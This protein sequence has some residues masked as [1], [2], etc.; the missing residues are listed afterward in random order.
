MAV[1]YGDQEKY[2]KSAKTDF[3][4]YEKYEPE[5]IDDVLGYPIVAIPERGLSKVTCSHFE[6]R[7]KL[8]EL[9]E[10]EAIYFPC[11]KEEGE[12]GSGQFYISG[13]KKKD[14]TKPKKVPKG[15]R[16]YHFTTVG[17]VDYDCL[18]FGIAQAK[19]FGFNRLVISEGEL[20]AGAYWESCAKF[21]KSRGDTH[22]IADLIILSIGFGT[23]TALKHI[24][25]DRNQY[26]LSKVEHKMLAFDN[27]ETTIEEYKKGQRKGKEATKAVITAY[28]GYKVSNTRYELNDPNDMHL[29]GRHD[30]LFWAMMKPDDY[31][32]DSFVDVE[33]FQDQLIILPKLGRLWPWESMNRITYGKNEG[34]GY[35]FGS[36]IGQG[37]SLIVDMI[38]DFQRENE[39]E[40]PPT[41]FKFEEQPEITIRKL[42]GIENNI[43]FHDPTKVIY[44]GNVDVWGDAI[45][46][47]ARGFF[48]EEDLFNAR[49]E[50][51]DESVIIYNTE[52]FPDWEKIK[53]DIRYAT[54]IRGSK[55][56]IIDPLTA[57][58]EG[59]EPSA[60]NTLLAQIARDLYLMSNE[61]GFNFYVFCH[62]NA[63][64][65][66]PPHEEGGKVHGYQFTGSK[67]MMRAA[68]GQ[69]GLE[70]D[71]REE[72]PSIIRNMSSL[73]LLKDR[74]YG[75][76]GR[77]FLHYDPDT[78]SYEEPSK[79]LLQDYQEALEELKGNSKGNPKGREKGPTGFVNED[80]V[81]DM[82]E[83]TE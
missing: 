6:I 83:A 38:V 2:E 8:N 36:G 27:D 75:N 40:A 70:R 35:Y 17:E 56:I 67:A 33:K 81:G 79:D 31:S 58:F 39:P 74:V 9:D 69:W 30:E 12:V 1:G 49:C 10:V 4:S 37:K 73:N 52:G 46:S 22:K 3:K 65:F 25:T 14:L 48:N 18:L 26:Y 51:D 72:L 55:D 11:H 77:F 23:A 32:S 5:S 78:G 59:L 41:I 63:P 80:W 28:P 62:L 76:T 82:K 47:G 61:I 43:R 24:S 19:S 50:F 20:D 13:Y 7:C 34:D 54:L 64:K 15:E 16:S 45:P 60:A 57:L 21:H 68:V 66:G 29:A 44:P 42:M 71:R 53:G